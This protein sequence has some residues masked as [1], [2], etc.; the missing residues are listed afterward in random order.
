[1]KV[2][3][4]IPFIASGA[5]PMVLAIWPAACGGDNMAAGNPGAGGTG[6]I[7]VIHDDLGDQPV[8]KLSGDQIQMFHL[9]DGLFDLPFR[10]SDG[11]GPLYIR[12][13]CGDCHQNGG[14]GPGSVHKFQMMGPDGQPVAT[15]PEVAYGDT[16]RPYVAGGG[17]TPIQAPADVNAPDQL[18][19]SVRVGPPVLGRG[20]IEAIDDAEIERVAAEQATRTDAIHGRINRV[21][22]HSAATSQAF[23]HHTLGET[24]VIGRFGH[25]ARV[26][27]LDDFTADA[28]QGDMGMTSPLRPTEVKNPDNLLDD[29]K[30]GVDLTEDNV[31]QVAQYV[32]SL[33]I[34]DRDPALMQSAGRA[35]FDQALCSVCHVPSLHTRA[36]NPVAVLAD[37]DAPVFSDI[38]LHDMGDGLADDLPD[39]SAGLREWRTAPLIALRFQHTFLHD[40]RATTVADA[41]AAHASA[42]SQANDSVARF[43]ALSKDDQA[44]LLT[45]VQ[46][47]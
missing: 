35:L 26:S 29:G 10:D 9:G 33:A 16:V 32:R 11:L 34:P 18:V 13:A 42:G 38:L 24:G 5:L 2:I 41:I 12:N 30:P 19:Q 22:Y 6:G 47:L 46:G 37:V 39:E 27:T 23:I 17:Q 8:T 7:T 20:Y 15:A 45:F 3:F 21:V 31:T 14:R 36:D 28:F 25:K 4:K 43:Q 44:S 40:G 1:L